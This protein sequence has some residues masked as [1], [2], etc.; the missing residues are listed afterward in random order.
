MDCFGALQSFDRVPLR[1]PLRP[2]L[3]TGFG[4]FG[5]WSSS[6]D[7]RVFMGIRLNSCLEGSRLQT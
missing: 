3:G 6:T 1:A 7:V 5:K 4:M 2:W